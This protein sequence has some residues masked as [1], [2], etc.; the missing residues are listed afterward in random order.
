MSTPIVDRHTHTSFS[1]GTSTFEQNVADVA[2]AQRRLADLLALGTKGDGF[3]WLPSGTKRTRPL[4][5]ALPWRFCTLRRLPA[6][7]NA[8]ATL[9]TC[10]K[11][12]ATSVRETG[13]H[14]PPLT[15]GTHNQ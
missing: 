13:R 12:T 11:A 6:C 15:V 9:V 1:D 3:V 8:T 10:R 7:R 5:S 2:H 14:A 4:W